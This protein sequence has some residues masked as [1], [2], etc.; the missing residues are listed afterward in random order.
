MCRLKF[1]YDIGNPE[2]S[3]SARAGCSE[4][5][6]VQRGVYV[7]LQEMS[8]RNRAAPRTALRD[9]GLHMLPVS[10]TGSNSRTA[11]RVGRIRIPRRTVGRDAL[12]SGWVGGHTQLARCY[13]NAIQSHVTTG[14][15]VWLHNP[16]CQAIGHCRVAVRVIPAGCCRF[17]ARLAAAVRVGS[18]DLEIR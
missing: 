11:N 15:V 17:L 3:C 14:L 9:P 7:F 6:E 10:R 8:F 2:K 5:N 16:I 12:T 18:R 1:S 13:C 4:K